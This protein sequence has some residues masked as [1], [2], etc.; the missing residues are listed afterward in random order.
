LKNNLCSADGGELVC[1]HCIEMGT[2]QTDHSTAFDNCYQADINSTL[3]APQNDAAFM[4]YY[5][6]SFNEV[7][8]LDEPLWVSIA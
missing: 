4:Y 1:G 5:Y 2:S 3:A 7:S 8:N 6:N